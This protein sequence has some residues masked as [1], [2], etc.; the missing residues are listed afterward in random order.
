MN[1]SL[2]ALSPFM[3]MDGMEGKITIQLTHDT[4]VVMGW[5]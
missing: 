5:S 1:S 3:R 2:K 4:L